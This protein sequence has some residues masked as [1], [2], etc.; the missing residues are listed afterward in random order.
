[1]QKSILLLFALICFAGA[2]AQS[3]KGQLEQAKFDIIKKTVEFLSTDTTIFKNTKSNKCNN[4]TNLKDLKKFA[5]DNVLTNAVKYVIDP[6][7]VLQIDS[8]T[9]KWNESLQQFKMQ[10]HDKIT[11]PGKEGRKKLK[12]YNDYLAGLNAIVAAVHPAQ[13]ITL[14]SDGT[15]TP[16]T[17]T[18]VR[19][20]A[21]T[22]VIAKDP[23]SQSKGLLSLSSIWL[24]Y[25]IAFILL[26]LLIYT[27]SRNGKIKQEK[28]YYKGKTGRLIT[29]IDQHKQTIQTLTG[30]NTALIQKLNNSEIDVKFYQDRL[31]SQEEMNEPV[32]TQKIELP[33]TTVEKPV[34]EKRVTRPSVQRP[35]QPIVNIKF[36]KY[37]DMGD[38]FSNSELLDKPNNETIFE[39]SLTSNNSGEYKVSNNPDAQ[40]YA[41]LNTQYFLGKTCLYDSFPFE[42]ASIRTDTPGT[43]QLNGGKWLIITQAKISFI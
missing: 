12:T 21:D 13:A 41:L 1:M 26:G 40:K 23:A 43:I 42:N 25:G 16:I 33:I 3:L 31:K 10:A 15:K 6:L 5:D 39:V 18:Q 32:S 35:A 7:A 11:G 36:A 4:C 37:A 2:N 29:E 30:E 24:P 22:T 27:I 34:T 9:D 38:G 20:N 17:L 8:S 28:E 19:Q 14:T